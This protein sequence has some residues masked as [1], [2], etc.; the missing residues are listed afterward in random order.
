MDLVCIF[1]FVSL[2]LYFSGKGENIWD[3]F[4]HATVSPI[5]DKSTGDVACDSYHKYQVDVQ[6]IKNMGVS[7]LRC[8]P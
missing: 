5:F 8:S 7:A 4:T 3:R 2:T 1:A 6:L